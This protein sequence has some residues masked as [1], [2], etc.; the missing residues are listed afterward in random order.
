MTPSLQVRFEISY[1]YGQIEHWPEHASF[2]SDEAHA[3]YFTSL[4][5]I[6][7]QKV[8]PSFLT[9]LTDA[10]T[11]HLIHTP[12]PASNAVMQHSFPRKHAEWSVEW[13]PFPVLERH[14]ASIHV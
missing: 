11:H 4:E 1:R 10:A 6:F 8:P 5:R 13:T 14:C 9:Q 7:V 12:D 2:N 3:A